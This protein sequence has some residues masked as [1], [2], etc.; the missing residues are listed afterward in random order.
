MVCG[1]IVCYTLTSTTYVNSLGWPWLA[2]HWIQVT[3]IAGAIYS[4]LTYVSKRTNQN[5]SK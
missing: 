3:T 2:K 4:F 1:F 5:A